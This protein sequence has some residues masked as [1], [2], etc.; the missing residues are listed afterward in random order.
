MLWYD[1]A[2]Y[3]PVVVYTIGNEDRLRQLRVE[4]QH[5]EMGEVNIIGFSGDFLSAFGSNGITA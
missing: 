2:I 3:V 1:A 4:S 5:C